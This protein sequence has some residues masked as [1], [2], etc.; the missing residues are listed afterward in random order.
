MRAS[1]PAARHAVIGLEVPYG[2]HHRL[3]P[4][5]LLAFFGS[6]RDW[7]SIGPRKFGGS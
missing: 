3:T 1:P 5:E 6:P 7:S 2:L 4:L